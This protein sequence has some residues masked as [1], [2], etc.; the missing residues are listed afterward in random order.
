MRDCYSRKCTFPLLWAD[1]FTETAPRGMRTA[2]EPGASTDGLCRA[3]ETD[4]S[5][6]E[7]SWAGSRVT[8]LIR[9]LM[10][11]SLCGRGLASLLGEC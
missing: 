1:C 10:I 2:P 4:G 8:G 7:V 9:R 3:A 6:G 5:A 11:H